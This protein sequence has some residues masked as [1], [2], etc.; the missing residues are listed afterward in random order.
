MKAKDILV[1][2][3]IS[4]L[5]LILVALG[6]SFSLKSSFGVAP[7]SCPPTAL[8]GEW[9]AL[10]FGTYTWIFNCSFILI[11]LL[12]QRRKFSWVLGLMQ[13]VAVILFGY[14]CDASNWLFNALD[15]QAEA[16]SMKI[17]WSLAAVVVTAVGIKLEVLGKGWILPI[18]QM[19][20]VITE[21][22]KFKY[23][24]VKILCDIAVVLMTVIFCWFA[25]GSLTGDPAALPEPLVIVFWGT[26]ILAFGVGLCM[27]LT[28]PLMDKIF[29]R[30]VK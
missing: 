9:P 7:P 20:A 3:A 18:D 1:R 26:L 19:N 10:S 11:Q 24:N 8:L 13:V 17:I 14:L 2:Y 5:G 29:G 28:D 30:F 27:K 4:T 22:G 12:L 15:A 25:F 23:S 21:M 16:L 6:V